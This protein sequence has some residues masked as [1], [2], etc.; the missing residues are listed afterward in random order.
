MFTSVN[1]S[2]NR[3]VTLGVKVQ[4]LTFIIGFLKN[5]SLFNCCTLTDIWAVDYPTRTK[6]FE[7]TYS[8]LSNKKNIRIY[9]K[10]HIGEWDVVSS[11]TALYQSAI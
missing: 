7:V 5:S 2:S 11:L 3:S 8:L 6:R 4:H 10:T 9:V 1:F